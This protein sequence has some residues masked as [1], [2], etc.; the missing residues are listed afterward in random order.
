MQKSPQHWVLGHR[1]TCYGRS[2]GVSSVG[3][4]RSME[5]IR[6]LGLTAVPLARSWET[7]AAWTLRRCGTAVAAQPGIWVS[8]KA[9][10]REQSQQQQLVPKCGALIPGG[11]TQ[12]STL[13]NGSVAGQCQV[14]TMTWDPGARGSGLQQ[15]LS[16]TKCYSDLIPEWGALHMTG[17]PRG[18]S[19]HRESSSSGE[20]IQ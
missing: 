8:L 6:S 14:R 15:L 5:Q 4:C 17:D 16:K 13:S 7:A 18:R 11:R 20:Q 1:C 10:L 3:V 12:R 9:S 2:T 19:Q